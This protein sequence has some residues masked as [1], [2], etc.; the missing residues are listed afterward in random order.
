MNCPKCGGDALHV[1]YVAKDTSI[2][3]SEIVEGQADYVQ[4]F[5]PETCELIPETGLFRYVVEEHLMI[6]CKTCGYA[7][8]QDT[9][10][11]SNE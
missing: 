3:K 2:R 6:T 11:A 1:K 4:D 5:A 8:A 10:D 9:N 7:W